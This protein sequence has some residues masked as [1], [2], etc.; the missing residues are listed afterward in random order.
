M[1]GWSLTT[2]GSIRAHPPNQISL[3]LYTAARRCYASLAYRGRGPAKQPCGLESG[4][5]TLRIAES[6]LAP[7]CRI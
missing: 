1:S 4:P 7:R 2:R 6:E 3:S 5:S